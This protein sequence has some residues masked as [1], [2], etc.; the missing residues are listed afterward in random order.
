MNHTNIKADPTKIR[1]KTINQK[2][3]EISDGRGGI[4]LQINVIIREAGASAKTQVTV[5]QDKEFLNLGSSLKFSLRES[6][7]R[8]LT[9]VNII[10]Q[11]ST[12]MQYLYGK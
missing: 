7:A 1:F 8:I 9:T 11:M 5:D 3:N 10:F 4:I 12:V 2:F 6:W